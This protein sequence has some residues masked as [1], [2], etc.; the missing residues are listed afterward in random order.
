MRFVLE[1]RAFAFHAQ[2]TTLAGYLQRQ[3]RVGQATVRWLEKYADAAM[4]AQLAGALRTA[5]RQKQSF[6]EVVAT[7]LATYAPYDG[8]TVFSA[9]KY[10]ELF[11]WFG[12]LFALA[13]GLGALEKKDRLR[14]ILPLY[15]ALRKSDLGSLAAY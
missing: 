8:T 13:V 14:A 2:G 15:G 1:P 6:D 7:A 10:S 9:E 3:R 4:A 12:Q 5:L 11:K